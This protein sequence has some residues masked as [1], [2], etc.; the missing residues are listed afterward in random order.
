MCA[1]L[2][3]KRSDT[4]GPRR[5]AA[6]GF[7]LLIVGTGSLTLLLRPTIGL[8]A[9]MPSLL[10]SGIG[11]GLVSAPLAGIA[12]RSLEPSLVGAASGVFNTTRQLGGA[13]GSAA[14]GVLLQA[15]LGTTPT[16]ATQAALAFPVVMLVVGLVC[17]AVVRPAAAVH[18]A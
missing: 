5:L 10:V 8:W 14:T 9:L 16:T 1:R 18:P 11:I 4:T 3:G 13:L 6:L 15:E 12:T 7:A 17:C 2:A